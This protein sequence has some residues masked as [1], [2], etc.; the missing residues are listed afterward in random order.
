MNGLGAMGVPNDA[1]LP[2]PLELER[3]SKQIFYNIKIFHF[4][5]FEVK[6]QMNFDLQS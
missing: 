5:Q 3:R 2:S 6:S 1:N 4:I